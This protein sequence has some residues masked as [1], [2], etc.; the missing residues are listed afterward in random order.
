MRLTSSWRNGKGKDSYEN[1]FNRLPEASTSSW[2]W[3]NNAAVAVH[4]ER[5][6]G[7]E[8]YEIGETSSQANAPLK[9]IRVETTVVQEI[10][11]R[12]HYHNELF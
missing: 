8:D 10:H 1:S 7:A 3:S 11:E 5:G 12:L 9:G 6:P 2:G 4:G